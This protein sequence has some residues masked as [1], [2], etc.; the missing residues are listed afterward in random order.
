MEYDK[1]FLKQFKVNNETFSYIPVD[2]QIHEVPLIRIG[3]SKSY[4]AMIKAETSSIKQFQCSAIHCDLKD[5][6]S[7]VGC[8]CLAGGR[9]DNKSVVFKIEYI[10]Q[11]S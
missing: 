5:L 7:C 11:I 9:E 2:N 8:R 1:E 3:T 10:Y 6:D 4:F